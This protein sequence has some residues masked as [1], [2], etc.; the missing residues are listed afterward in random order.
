[1]NA[2]SKEP[3]TSTV[4]SKEPLETVIKDLEKKVNPKSSEEG[5]KQLGDAIRNNDMSSLLA[6]M[7]DG[8]KEFEERVGRPMT[9]G[10]MRAMWG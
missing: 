9:Y 10:E 3:I 5:L 7:Q 1:M 4:S 8:A 2:D 6:P